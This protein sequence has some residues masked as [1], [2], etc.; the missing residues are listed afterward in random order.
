MEI[1]LNSDGRGTY[2][3]GN[4]VYINKYFMSARNLFQ[5]DES[6]V[7]SKSLYIALKCAV[8]CRSVNVENRK[9][10]AI[11]LETDERISIFKGCKPTDLDVSLNMYS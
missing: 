9:F 2:H 11:K 5:G 4:C 8:N 10:W 7:R 1:T 3:V 6:R